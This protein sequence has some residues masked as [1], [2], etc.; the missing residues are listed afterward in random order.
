M[1]PNRFQEDFCV[2]STF[3]LSSYKEVKMLPECYPNDFGQSTFQICSRRFFGGS[4]CECSSQKEGKCCPNISKNDFPAIRLFKFR[5]QKRG[6]CCPIFQKNRSGPFDLQRSSSK[7]GEMLPN[8]FQEYFSAI[9]FSTH[10]HKKKPCRH[11]RGK[12]CQVT[13]GF[14]HVDA[15]PRLTGQ[16]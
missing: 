3:N 13:R 6:K 4:I 10:R 11:R 15:G 16:T 14:H 12:C 2:C 9:I 8:F 7:A 1:L 5:H